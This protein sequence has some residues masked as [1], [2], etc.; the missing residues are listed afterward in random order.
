MTSSVRSI[1]R[2]FFACCFGLVWVIMVIVRLLVDGTVASLWV[3]KLALSFGR[4]LVGCIPGML[5]LI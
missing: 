4:W 2:Y 3:W 1:V 5:E